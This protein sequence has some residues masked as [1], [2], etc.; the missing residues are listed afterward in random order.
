[1]EKSRTTKGLTTLLISVLI[2]PYIAGVKI[3]I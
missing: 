2:P 3:L 1:M